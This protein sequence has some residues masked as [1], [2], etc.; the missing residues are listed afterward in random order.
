MNNLGRSEK[1]S[2]SHSNSTSMFTI[3][4][5]STAYEIYKRIIRSDYTAKRIAKELNLRSST[6]HYHIKNL[7]NIRLIK[8]INPKEQIKFYEK[9]VDVFV[10]PAK[11]RGSYV[12]S[13][14]DLGRG[15]KYGSLQP[16]DIR[17]KKVIVNGESRH[18]LARVHGIAY[19]V[20]IL[21]K[22]K[23]KYK[24]IKWD[25]T[26]KPRDR[27]EQYIK[28][29]KVEGVGDVSY[30]WI[31]SNKK[32]TLIAYLPMIY[33]LPHEITEYNKE[34]ILTDYAWQSFRHFV[35]TY[36][37]GI[38]RIPERVGKKSPHIAY[39]ASKKQQ[40]FIKK[41]GT[42]EIKTPNGKIM[43]DDS[44]DDGGEVEADNLEDIRLYNEVKEDLLKPVEIVNLKN[45]VISL[46]SHLSDMKE[47]TKEHENFLKEFTSTFTQYLVQDKNKWETQ[48]E[49]N[50]TVKE[51]MERTDGQIERVMFEVGLGKQPRKQT[52]LD[53]YDQTNGEIGYV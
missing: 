4:I 37:V 43:L 21:E 53:I 15:S 14:N 22:W 40:E 25:S 7:E 16:K 46:S 11:N 17:Q 13:S 5:G 9:T 36:Q 39:P 27:F 38:D 44:M 26:S 50:E 23:H 28:K 6:I 12:L 30:K 34:Q 48:K 10:S 51:Y 29:D 8:C 45:N 41:F 47:K 20:P 42:L 1:N 3:K 18:E 31:H 35:K 24:E 33:F 52:S 19:K 2:N 32:D 49:F